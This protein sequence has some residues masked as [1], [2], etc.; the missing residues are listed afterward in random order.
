M[1]DDTKTIV[2]ELRKY[3]DRDYLKRMVRFGIHPENVLGV[4]VP[5]IRKV[6]KKVPHDVQTSKNLWSSGIHEARILAT[7]I[8]PPKEL[9]AE[10]AGTMAN[11]LY[12]WDLCD[13]LVG[14]LIANSETPLILQLIDSWS[15]ETAEYTRRAAFSLIASLDHKE[16]YTA[17]NVNHF[18]ELIEKASEDNR[19]F[20]KKAVNWAL[21][22][23]GKSNQQNWSLALKAAEK[24]R[25]NKTPA[26]KWIG[27]N[28]VRELQSDDVKRRLSI[29]E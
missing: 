21:R 24:I 11:D 26:G 14:N 9:N 10:D 12:S 29:E 22:E 13:H 25:A 6:S 17:E 16:I 5:N 7:M 23:I 8:Y 2:D 18:L 4:S 27:S 1:I 20:V 15:M 3:E 19:N 28:A